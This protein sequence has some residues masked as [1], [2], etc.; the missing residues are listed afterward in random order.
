MARFFV[1]AI[2]LDTYK[3]GE[4]IIAQP[5]SHVWT[6]AEGLPQFWQID[7]S[8][9]PWSLARPFVGPLMEPAM[10]GD[11]ELGAP[12][13][14]NR[15]IR[16]SRARTHFFPDRL[17]PSKQDELAAEGCTTLNFGQGRTAFVRMRWDRTTGRPVDTGARPF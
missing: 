16:R 14:E 5:D 17:P 12:D 13:P 15:F 3:A 6:A 9:L 7:V 1:A 10:P 8:P 2:D 4:L 11:P